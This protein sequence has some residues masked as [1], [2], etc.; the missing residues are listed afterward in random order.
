MPRST[1][2]FGIDL[3]TTNSE[4]AVF[5]GTS[6]E[7]IK[8]NDNFENTSSAVWIDKHGD[9]IIGQRA[10]EMFQRDRANAKVKFKLLMGSK[11]YLHFAA[12][13]KKMLPEELSAEVL[14]QLKAN[15]RERLGEDIYAAVITVPADFAAP[16]IEAT[17]QAARLAGFETSALLQ[18]P[19]AAAVAY[20]FHQQG[21]ADRAR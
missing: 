11:D 17:N 20:G 5:E 3:G 7:I 12:S 13:G 9:M 19:V 1:I 8:N 14:K 4:I 18:E 2:D 6:T 16:Q 10:K 15:V 21:G